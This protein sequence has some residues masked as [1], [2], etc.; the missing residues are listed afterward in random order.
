[1]PKVTIVGAGNVG[2]TAAHIIAS[3]NLADVVLVDVAEG[4][5]QGKALDMMHMRGV[6]K[7]TVTVSG[8]NDYEA[9][10][11]S[12]VVV[13][14]AGIARKPGMTREDLLGVNAGIM[15]SVI[16]AAL[17][18][19][20][21]A[22]YICVTNPLDVMTY[23]AYKKSGLPTNRL[24]GMGGVLDSSRLSFAVCEK[25]GCLPEDVE[26]WALGAHGEGMVCW[27]RFTTVQG[28]PI[29]ELM[30]E[31]D[32]EAVVER[33]VK[34]GA[35]VVAHLKTGSA[36]YAPGAS[37]AKMVEA[38]LGDTKEIMSVCAY[39]DGEYGIE[40]LYM[41][42]PVRLG[43]GGV[44]EIVEF[45]LTDD[46]LAALQASAASVRAGLANLPE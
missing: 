7:F 2:A 36:Y 5:P 30:S 10:K 4:L 42:I 13:I 34:G 32:V 33:T 28:T 37:I 20:P 46:E 18:A 40:D 14:T 26:A 23:L 41:N 45:D 16:D 25:L 22:V 15:S 43:K 29:T 35:E 44:E 1:M 19:S 3:K 17:E 31:D 9:T 39:I 27:P 21:D 11:D 38:I 12:D 24:M 8:S 6:E